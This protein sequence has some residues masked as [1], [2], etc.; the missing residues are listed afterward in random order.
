VLTATIYQLYTKLELLIIVPCHRGM[1]RP[2]VRHGGG[3]LEIWKVGANV[4]N[5]QSQTAD[6]GWSSSLGRGIGMGPATPQH[7]KKPLVTKCY[8]GPRTWTDSVERLKLT[9]MVPK[10]IE[11]MEGW[12]ELLN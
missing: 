2:Q 10:R 4:L 7:K 1:A 11:I 9:K 12:R 6:K 8:T 5:K 3:G